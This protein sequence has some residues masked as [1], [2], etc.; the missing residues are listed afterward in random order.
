HSGGP[1]FIQV[2]YKPW[3]ELNGT[4]SGWV[5]CVTDITVLRKAQE[6]LRESENRL[7]AIT[8]N[9]PIAIALYD[10]ADRVQFANPEYIKLAAKSDRPPNGVASAEYQYKK[11]YDR[12]VKFRER[13]L[14]GESSRFTVSRNLDGMQREF[15]VSYLPYRDTSGAIVGV[16]GMGYD[17]TELRESH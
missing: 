13:A 4:V 2:V 12:T 3:R 6:E 5:A 9:L 10:R 16:Y 14:Q 8:E 1:H 11:L 17:V 7:R 15:E